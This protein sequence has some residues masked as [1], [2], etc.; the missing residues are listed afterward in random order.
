VSVTSI[1][2]VKSTATPLGYLATFTSDVETTFNYAQTLTTSTSVTLLQEFRPPPNKTAHFKD[3]IFR[4]AV[5][6]ANGSA[7][8]VV[9]LRN[10]NPEASNYYYAY[11]PTPDNATQHWYDFSYDATTGTGAKFVGNMI[12]LHFVD[13]Q[14]GD[15]DSINGSVTHIGALVKL[16][17][18]ATESPASNG[19]SISTTPSPLTDNGD[20]GLVSLFLVFLAFARKRVRRQRFYRVMNIASP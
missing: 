7:S 19:C 14:H 10:D 8:R 20:W 2:N 9:T 15:R 11:G 3:G 16:T 4:F 13:G 12:L 18:I 17:D 1:P 6:W 5:T